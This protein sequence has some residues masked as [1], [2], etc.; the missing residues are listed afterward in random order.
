MGYVIAALAVALV[1][2][3]VWFYFLSVM[4]LLEYMARNGL[5]P[6]TEEEISRSLKRIRAVRKEE[7]ICKKIRKHKE[8]LARQLQGLV[9]EDLSGEE[10]TVEV[11]YRPE[12][13][14]K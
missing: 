13:P 12:K 1:I 6:P 14:E 5:Q 4:I 2:F 11:E 9:N 8:K 7:K 10:T 3:L